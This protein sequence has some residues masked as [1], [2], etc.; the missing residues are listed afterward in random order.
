MA[1][2]HDQ[3]TARTLRPPSQRR[4]SPHGGEEASPADTS[5]DVRVY[6]LA[7]PLRPFFTSLYA[8]TV[9]CPPGT[10]VFD[11]LH[12]EWAALRFTKGSPPLACIGSGELVERSPFVANGPTSRPT[13]FAVTTSQIWGLRLHPAGWAAF[14]DHPAKALSDRI[15]DGASHPAFARLAPLMDVIRAATGSE[16]QV[17]DRINEFLMQHVHRRISRMPAILRCQEALIDPAIASVTKLADRVELDRRALERLCE[18]YF[19][20]PPKLLLRR[21]RFLRSLA[22]FMADPQTRWSKAMD[23]QYCDQAQ[24]VHDF[25]RF[26]GMTP[27]EYAKAE[28]PLLCIVIAD[29]LADQGASPHS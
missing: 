12:P 4:W 3:A 15:V 7:E 14:V 9:Q 20:F 21:Q 2:R 27:Q 17:A 13:H 19:G 11:C 26:M 10:Y 5:I 23:E 8:T 6:S 28:H 22:K 29:R 24:F 18:R 1:P 16:D 25:R